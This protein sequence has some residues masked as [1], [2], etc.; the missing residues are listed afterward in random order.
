VTKLTIK[1]GCVEAVF[2]RSRIPSKGTERIQLPKN[3]QPTLTSE[4]P[5]QDA[6]RAPTQQM[7]QSLDDGTSLGK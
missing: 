5:L 6:E 3:E 2:K 1:S 4:T 7:I